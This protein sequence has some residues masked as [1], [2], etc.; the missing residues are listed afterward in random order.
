L[1]NLCNNPEHSQ[2]QRELDKILSVRLKETRDEFLPGPQY[3]AKWNYQWDGKDAPNQA[4][5]SEVKEK[6]S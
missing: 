2:V 6:Q 3:M 1:T 5:P 4:S